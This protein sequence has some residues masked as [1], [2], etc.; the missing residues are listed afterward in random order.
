MNSEPERNAN[1]ILHNPPGT[2]TLTFEALRN[3]PGT[4]GWVVYK[5]KDGLD[6]V[7]ATN[8]GGGIVWLEDEQVAIAL[9][10]LGSTPSAKS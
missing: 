1:D 4:K 10:A 3:H 7:G 5:S 9:T 2:P 8:E 6:H